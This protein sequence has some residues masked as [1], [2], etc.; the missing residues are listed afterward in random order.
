MN[1][2]YYFASTETMIVNDVFHLYNSMLFLQAV[3]VNDTIFFSINLKIFVL[4]LKE[5][6]F[7]SKL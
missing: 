3:S 5:F 6:V 1:E 2:S 4:F 7:L